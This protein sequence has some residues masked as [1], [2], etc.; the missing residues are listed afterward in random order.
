[1][2]DFGALLESNG[3]PTPDWI[4]SHNPLRSTGNQSQVNQS[5][6]EITEGADLAGEKSYS[7]IRLFGNDAAKKIESISLYPDKVVIHQSGGGH[8]EYPVSEQHGRTNYLITTA[9]DQMRSEIKINVVGDASQKPI[10]LTVEEESSSRKWP[11]EMRID[12]SEAP[13][14]TVIANTN[15]ATKVA[16]ENLSAE[17][18]KTIGQNPTGRLSNIVKLDG[19]TLAN[20]KPSG[21]TIYKSADP[22][23]MSWTVGPVKPD[24]AA[25]I[26]KTTGPTP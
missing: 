16:I 19:I 11:A 2:V 25:A 10:S 14:G 17:N 7:Q 26:A 21:M 22:Y 15:A 9:A 12:V 23:E 1:M 4:K 3:I 8:H 6:V 13:K 18:M 24:N 5:G 20:D